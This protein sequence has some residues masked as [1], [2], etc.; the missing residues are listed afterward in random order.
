LERI[1]KKPRKIFKLAFHKFIALIGVC[2]Y[3]TILV[4]DN[5]IF[6]NLHNLGKIQKIC[7]KICHNNFLRTTQGVNIKQSST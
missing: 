2:D 5:I 1:N 6:R 4:Y 7:E 3:A